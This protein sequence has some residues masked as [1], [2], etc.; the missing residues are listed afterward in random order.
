MAHHSR[1]ASARA[2]DLSRRRRLKGHLPGDL[3]ATS[4]KVIGWDSDGRSSAI[5]HYD[6]APPPPISSCLGWPTNRVMHLRVS[7]DHPPP[8]GAIW[9]STAA[10]PSAL[11]PRRFVRTPRP[12]A[13]SRC[14]RKVRTK[15]TSHISTRCGRV[16]GAA[17]EYAR[18]GSTHV[19]RPRPRYGMDEEATFD[20]RKLGANDYLLE[21][22]AGPSATSAAAVRRSA[23]TRP[24]GQ[25]SKITSCTR[26][27]DRMS[28]C[29]CRR[30]ESM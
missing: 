5:H 11:T 16:V 30:L 20:P 17:C 14:Y 13:S 8:S 9:G 26:W 4:S 3:A 15:T 10:R 24:H 12:T 1:G 23:L 29:T 25:A 7:E 22:G 2:F 6:G 19:A 18:R 21:A 27:S 28:A